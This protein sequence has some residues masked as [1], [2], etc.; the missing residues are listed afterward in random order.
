MRLLATRF[1]SS[2]GTCGRLAS[3]RGSAVSLASLHE[4]AEADATPSVTAAAG[5]G[6][7]ALA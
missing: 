2:F 1:E 5:V 3:P 4:I 7:R 6:L